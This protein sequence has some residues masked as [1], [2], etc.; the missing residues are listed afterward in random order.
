MSDATRNIEV[1]LVAASELIHADARAT[2]GGLGEV[3]GRSSEA[4]EERE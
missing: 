3:L 4:G 2:A 1:R